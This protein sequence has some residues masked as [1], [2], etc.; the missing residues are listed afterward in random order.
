MRETIG[1]QLGVI[2]EGSR[3]DLE[4]V[5]ETLLADSKTVREETATTLKGFNESLINNIGEMAKLQKNQLD[6]FS[7]RL[8][9]LTQTN[10]QK[11][12][13]MRETVDQR[14]LNV[15]QERSGKT[16]GE[17]RRIGEASVQKSREEVIAAL[18]TFNESVGKTI[19]DFI[20]WQRTAVSVVSWSS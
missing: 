5:R 8:D 16:L 7:E 17:M 1:Q 15:I 18:K 10:E 14:I 19:T 13:K 11:L 12:D 3:K 9:K 6:T 20:N 4:Q 2:Q